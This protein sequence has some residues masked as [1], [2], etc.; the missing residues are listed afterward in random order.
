MADIIKVAGVVIKNKKLLMVRKYS[1]D[2]LAMLGGK[3]ELNETQIECLK[4]EIL[5]EIGTSNFRIIDERPFYTA[6]SVAGS[7]ITKTLEMHCYKV[8]LF[9]DPIPTYNPQK[10][11]ETERGLN[12][13][14]IFWIGKSD[15]N[16]VN[17]KCKL[18]SQIKA[19]DNTKLTLTP[20]TED[21]ILPK[22][23]ELKLID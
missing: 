12:I 13:S 7:D 6:Y 23:I 19:S 5:E 4:R 21:L 10:P 2:F 20:I 18:I 8:E 1:Q 15:L 14:D 22:L 17:N 16:L 3:L 11:E 9:E